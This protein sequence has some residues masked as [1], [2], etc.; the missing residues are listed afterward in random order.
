MLTSTI[1]VR[2]DRLARAY[3]AQAL[4]RTVLVV[5]TL[6]PV[7]GSLLRSF[8]QDFSLLPLALPDPSQVFLPSAQ[9]SGQPSLLQYDKYIQTVSRNL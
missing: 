8:D 6:P 7:H 1:H 4:S 9:R 2:C 5:F 3:S